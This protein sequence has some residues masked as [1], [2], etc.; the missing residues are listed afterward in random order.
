MEKLAK[1]IHLIQA[2]MKEKFT[3]YVKIEFTRGSIS[4]VKRFEEILK[5]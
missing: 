1:I 3:G 2:L 5:K 4:I